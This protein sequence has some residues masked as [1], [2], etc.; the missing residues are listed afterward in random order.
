MRTLFLTICIYL[1]FLTIAISQSYNPLIRT[2]VYWDVHHGNNSL[3]CDFERGNRYFFQGD[4]T[5]NSV[6]YK[7]VRSFPIIQANSGP[8]CPPFIVNYSV[9]S[10]IDAFMREDTSTK[11]VYIYDSINQS[12][13]LLYDFSLSKGDTLFSL[14]YI[15]VIDTIQNITL[16]NGHTRKMFSTGNEFYIEGIGGSQGLFF[17]LTPGLGWLWQ[18][19]FCIT[20]NN[21]NIWGNGCSTFLGNKRIYNPNEA[22]VFPIPCSSYFYIERE[23]DKLTLLK[24]VD[25]IGKTVLKKKLNLKIERID[26]SKLNSGIYFYMIGK[27]QKGK[28][29]KQ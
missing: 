7:I 3:I 27:N 18:D 4:T 23:K 28:I 25:S 21:L 11:T 16:Q 26:I 6:Q 9:P 20:E 15:G 12:D 22:K 1:T 29:L 14:G 10:S 19:P 17:S 24:I 5:F 13:Q 2:N 8:Y